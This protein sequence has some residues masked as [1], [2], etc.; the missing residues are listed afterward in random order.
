MQAGALKAACAILTEF[1]I[2]ITYQRQ[3]NMPYS[4]PDLELRVTRG[5]Q[6][7]KLSLVEVKSTSVMASF[8]EQCRQSH[9]MCWELHGSL[10]GTITTKASEFKSYC[11]FMMLI[12]VQDGVLYW[13]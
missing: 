9:D 10:L 2:N 12:A 5:T 3:Y 8:A 1:G 13:L 11:L 7:S 4:R 6:P